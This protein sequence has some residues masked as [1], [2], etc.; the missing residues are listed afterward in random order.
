[1][2][3]SSQIIQTFKDNLSLQLVHNFGALELHVFYVY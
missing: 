2:G 1:M 3:Q